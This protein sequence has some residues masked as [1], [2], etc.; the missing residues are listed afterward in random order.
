MT[1]KELK[2]AL[3]A[4]PEN[5]N[6]NV[7]FNTGMSFHGALNETKSAVSVKRDGDTVILRG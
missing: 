5:A 4:M 7:S 6:V 2:A 1:V 3:E